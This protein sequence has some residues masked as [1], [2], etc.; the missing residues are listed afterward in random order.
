[1]LGD[2]GLSPAK[3]YVGVTLTIIDVYSQQYHWRSWPAIFDVL[4]ELNGQALLDLGCGV[5]DLAAD[6]SA[7][8]ASIVGVDVNEELIAYA[9]SRHIPNAVFRKSDLRTFLDTSL[10][11]DGIWSSFTA[12]YFPALSDILSRWLEHLR[13]GGWLALTEIDDLFGHYPLSN[14]TT[15]LLAL[16]VQDALEQSR[17]DFRMGRKISA[18]AER[19]GLEIVHDFS[20]PDAELSFTGRAAPDV[21]KAWE[22]RFDQMHLLHAFCG[23][24]F[25][26]VRDDF[27]NCLDRADHHCSAKVQCCIAIKLR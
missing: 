4:P 7:R 13:P 3:T 20:V 23:E 5:G 17:Y 24:E 26:L 16:Y 11:V 15:E 27:L 22:I 8:G 6:L 12:A 18:M 1:M 10:Y 19:V 2:L 14:R 21:Q 25:R 9:N